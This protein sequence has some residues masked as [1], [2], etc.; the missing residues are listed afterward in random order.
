MAQWEERWRASLPTSS[1][2]SPKF[3]GVLLGAPNP[4]G[5]ADSP[6]RGL[7]WRAEVFPGS[8]SP[9]PS[10]VPLSRPVSPAP[11]PGPGAP[12]SSDSGVPEDRVL[13]TAGRGAGLAGLRPAPP[14]G[15]DG[16]ALLLAEA[17]VGPVARLD[18]LA[19]AALALDHL[20]QLAV[21]LAGGLGRQG[22]RQ[23]Q[24][25]RRLGLCPFLPPP[26]PTGMGG[27]GG[28]RGSRT[29]ESPGPVPTAE[30]RGQCVAQKQVHS[31]PQGLRPL[32]L[33]PGARR[34]VSHPR[35]GRLF[36]A[37][38]PAGCI[39]PPRGDVSF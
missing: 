31:C 5:P 1:Q 39:F 27:E 21:A 34:C 37:V 12:A 32:S 28:I 15:E 3:L 13:P 30:R 35:K 6:S 24:R 38:F 4:M 10:S 29:S 26:A 23:R 16:H 8:L 17:A 7:G 14:A 18:L 36:K 2:P 9:G 33:R 22:Q 11:L 19:H 25:Q 20:Q